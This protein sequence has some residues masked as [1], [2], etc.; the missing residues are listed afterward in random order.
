MSL[1]QPESMDELI[2]FTKRS[3][4]DKGR[5]TVWVYRQKCPKCNKAL[6][7]KPKDP[8]TG[9]PKTRADEYCCP[10]CGY[11]EEKD[12]YEGSLNAEA[13]YTCPKC[14]FNGEQA[15]PFKRKKVKGVDALRFK[16]SKCSTDL[17]VTKKMKNIKNKG[18]E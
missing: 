3:I 15:I 18:E 10:E 16:C 1:K 17:L 13:V 9:L 2:Y 12:A 4:D 5:I 14:E 11:T 7:G 6:M 8:K